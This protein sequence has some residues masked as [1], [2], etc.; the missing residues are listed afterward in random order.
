MVIVN[1][2][3]LPYETTKID[4]EKTVREIGRRHS[5]GSGMMMSGRCVVKVSRGKRRRGMTE[6]GEDA[7]KKPVL[8]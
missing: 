8:K 5:S 4:E 6:V 3:H 2:L 7:R 1:N